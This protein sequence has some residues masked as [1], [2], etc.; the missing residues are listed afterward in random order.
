MSII[1]SAKTLWSKFVV[2]VLALNG[3]EYQRGVGVYAY[4]KTGDHTHLF[5]IFPQ[6][7]L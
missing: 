7:T 4:P 5:G 6:S 3:Y 1:R 2:L